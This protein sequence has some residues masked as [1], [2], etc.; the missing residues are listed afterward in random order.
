[1]KILWLPHAPLGQGRTRTEH[2][3]ERLGRRHDI[4]VLSFRIHRGGQAWRYLTDLITFRS[5]PGAR[6]R[7]LVMRRFPRAAALNGWMLRRIT[8][9]AVAREKYDVI[10]VTPAPWV[11]GYPDFD[12]MRAHAPVV[13]D[14]LDGVDWQSGGGSAA[15]EK[16]YVRSSDAAMCAS[17]RLAEQASALNPH[18]EYVPNGVDL[19]RLTRFAATHTAAECKAAL[20][21][22]PAAFVVSIIGLTVS[23]RL[24]FID[25]VTSLARAGRN[26]ALLLVGESPLLGR[27]RRRAAE[28]SRV[29]RITGA[30]PYAD[31]L[32]YFMASDLGL[33]PVD[34]DSYY[35]C[36]SPLKILEYGAIGKPVLVSPRLDEVARMALSHVQF[37]GAD[38]ESV[39]NGIAEVMDS[40]N[41]VQRPAL[42]AYDWDVIAGKVESVLADAAAGYARRRKGDADRP[43]AMRTA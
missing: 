33:Y 31:V 37:C 26:V 13:C 29:L 21:I 36:A 24:Y 41:R 17:H 10:V 18:A 25:A 20:G 42:D 35:H 12:A 27:I 19:E 16:L 8:A 5:K 43:A 34:D 9:R 28:W 40:G 6:Y 3:V 15:F 7:E 22:A 30:V 38:A 1:V 39:A 32:P 4:D 23:P 11:T 14:Y 2:L